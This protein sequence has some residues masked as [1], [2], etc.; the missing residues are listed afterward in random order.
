MHDVRSEESTD[1][2]AERKVMKPF[3]FPSS[4]PRCTSEKKTKI[5][6]RRRDE[7]TENKPGK[8]SRFSILKSLFK[9]YEYSSF[10][11]FPS[12]DKQ[13]SVGSIRI[14]LTTERNETNEDE[15]KKKRTKLEKFPGSRF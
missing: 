1:R 14:R 9:E 3:G 5:K 8:V 7:E 12:P 10:K 13:S 11:H 2:D 4:L 15:M 6:K